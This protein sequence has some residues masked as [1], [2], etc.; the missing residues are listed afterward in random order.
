MNRDRVVKEQML[1]SVIQSSAGA[2]VDAVR[3]GCCIM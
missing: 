3:H 1:G 2:A